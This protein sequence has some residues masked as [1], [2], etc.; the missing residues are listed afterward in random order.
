M[1]LE[2]D[3][4]VSLI[5]SSFVQSAKEHLGSQV[6]RK[7]FRIVKFQWVNQKLMFLLITQTNWIKNPMWIIN[8]SHFVCRTIQ[9]CGQYSYILNLF[10]I[11]W[12]LSYNTM[13][14]F[15]CTMC[16]ACSIVINNHHVTTA[17]FYIFIVNNFVM[18]NAIM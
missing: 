4:R 8:R 5:Q 3:G 18:P 2:Q 7:Y 12:E 9:S 10:V 15:I 1:H 11:L 6:V 17:M 14:V 13:T 16:G